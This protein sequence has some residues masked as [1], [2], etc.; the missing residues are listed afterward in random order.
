MFDRLEQVK[1]TLEAGAMGYVLKASG[2]KVLKE[3]VIAVM[4]GKKYLDPHLS[5]SFITENAT[6]SNHKTLLSNREKEILYLI[7][8]GKSSQEIADT[9]FISK[10]TVDTHRKNMCRKLEL[11]GSHALLQYALE[12]KFEF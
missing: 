6:P 11:Q 7:S 4:E 12:T 8:Q 3:S 5:F 2:L 10:T 9:L 1:E